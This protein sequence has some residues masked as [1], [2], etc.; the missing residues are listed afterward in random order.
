M[1]EFDHGMQGQ[2]IAALQSMRHHQE[3]A[4]EGPGSGLGLDSS[5]VWFVKSGLYDYCAVITGNV[6]NVMQSLFN[7]MFPSEWLS[8][9]DQGKL[10]ITILG[11]PVLIRWSFGQNDDDGS[12]AESTAGQMQESD[13]YGSDDDVR[14]FMN[15]YPNANYN[16]MDTLGEDANGLSG[17]QH[18]SGQ[19]HDYAPIM[20]QQEEEIGHSIG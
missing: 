2:N 12:D 14:S 9:F 8:I 6:D 7:S 20:P 16:I 4:S 18:S 17:I 1:S 15:D 19:G 11:F 5:F 13:S 3:A 10:N